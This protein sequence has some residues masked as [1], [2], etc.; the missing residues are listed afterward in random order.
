MHGHS[1]DSPDFQTIVKLDERNLQ[2]I[3]TSSRLSRHNKKIMI[4]EHLLSRLHYHLI[5]GLI[6]Q[7]ACPTNSELAH[8]LGTPTAHIEELLQGLSDIHGVVL[9]P[10]V[11]EPWV[12]HPFSLTPTTNW[13]RGQRGGW[14]AQCVWCAL[15]VTVLVGGETR[16]H[17]RLGGEA[18]SLAIPVVEGQ[19]VGF[20]ELWVHFAIPPARA[21]QN[22]HQHCS[23]V[24]P[25]RS[26]EEIRD[27]C[28]RHRLPHGE[29]V[30]LHQVAR[31]AQIWYGTHAD[32]TWH[33]WT[34]AEAQAIFHQAGLH[35][36]FWDLGAT[37]GKF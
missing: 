21:W 3:E 9:H 33:K 10:H 32:P 30:P 6:E 31:L 25:F 27:W 19:P 7:C 8:Q 28:D 5:R 11:C 24:L 12:I 34:V 26:P 36:Q 14:W 16:I 2:T 37:S 22:V 15:G 29:A 4:N 35:S 23:M 18:E 1:P 13:I 17:T 20:D